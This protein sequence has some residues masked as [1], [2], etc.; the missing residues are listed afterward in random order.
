VLRFC[1]AFILVLLRSWV[2]AEAAVTLAAANKAAVAA[3]NIV[4]FGFIAKRSIFN[5][6][7]NHPWPTHGHSSPH[8]CKGSIGFEQIWARS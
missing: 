7:K 4:V 1:P 6:R 2:C 8:I 3:A 5:S